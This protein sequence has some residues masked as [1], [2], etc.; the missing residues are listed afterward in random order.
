MAISEFK[1]FDQQVVLITKQ[2]YEKLLRSRKLLQC[3]EYT[4]VDNWEGYHEA[5]KEFYNEEDEE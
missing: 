1:A 3:L 2:E 5:T 4:G